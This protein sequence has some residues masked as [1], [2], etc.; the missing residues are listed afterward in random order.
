M[1]TKASEPELVFR[2]GTHLYFIIGIFASL[3]LA[4]GVLIAIKTNEWA[5]L[6][7]VGGGTAVL[8]A[9]VSYLKLVIRE[10]GFTYRNLSM[11]RSVE[12]AE[13]IKACFETVHAR[14]AP[15]GAAAFWVH[16]GDGTAMKINLRMFPI[17]AA[18]V[19]FSTLER[20]G[21]SIEVPDTWA[22]QRM[23]G[24]I[25]AEQDKLRSSS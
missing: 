23:A 13:I 22:A 24:Q 4:L 17:R 5:F 1:T 16:L 25:R 3:F 6:A 7:V 21:I 15:Q 12:F 8:Y 20:H 2:A 10:N 11:N 14:A 9:L 18:A 19:L